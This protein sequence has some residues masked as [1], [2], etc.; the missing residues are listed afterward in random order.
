M[1]KKQSWYREKH[2][3]FGGSV[4]KIWTVLLISS[5]LSLHANSYPQKARITLDVHDMSLENILKEIESKTEFK[6]I[7]NVGKIDTGR[8]VSIKADNRPV[9]YILDQI[10]EGTGIGYVLRDKL[11]LLRPEETG[12]AENRDR[13]SEVQGQV[14]GTVTDE[15]GIPLPGVTVLIQGST[16]GTTT[17][18]DGNYSIN[19]SAEATLQFSYIGFETLEEEVANRT[20]VDIRMETSVEEIEEVVIIGYGEVKKENITGSVGVVDME[21]FHNQAPAINVDQGLQGLVAGVNVSSPNGQPGSASKIRIRGTTSL[22]GSNQPLFVIDGIPVVAESN[23]PIGGSEG[24]SL[25]QELDNQGLSTP[26]GNINPNDIESI[27]VLKDASAAAIYGSRAAN[28]VIII[29]T[30]QGSRNSDVNFEFDLSSSIQE[31]PG[32]DV[33]NATQ[34]K[35]AWTTAVENSSRTDAF[36]NAVRDGSYFGDAD[37]NWEDIM[38][39]GNRITT[40]A[41]FSARGGTS[42]TRYSASLS[43]LDE[44]AGFKGSERKRYTI[45]L[46]LN[47]NA[48]RTWNFGTR[49][50][51]TYA[52]QFATDAGLYDRIFRFRPDLPVR[53]EDGNYTFSPY[54][55]LE[56]PAALSEANN[57]NNTFLFLGTFFTGLELMEG[58]KAETRLSVN[59]NSGIQK[60]FYPAFTFR[61]GWS[62]LQGTGEG[63]A[64]DSRSQSAVTQW[65]TT[66]TYFRQWDELHHV[67]AVLGTTFENVNKSY[68]KAFGEGFSN[69]I[70]DNVSSATLGNGGLSTSE[71]SGLASYFGRLYYDYDSRYLAT[72]VGRVDGSSKFAKENKYAFFPAVAVAWRASEEEFLRGNKTLNNLKFKASIGKTGQQDLGAYQWRTLYETYQYG[73]ESAVILTQLGNDRL[74]WETTDQLDFG[75]EFGLFDNRISGEFGYYRKDTYDAIFPVIPPVSTGIVTVLANAGETRNTGLELLLHADLIRSKDFSWNIRVN[76]TRNKNVLVS[77]GD[78]YKDENGIV[79]GIPN[80][81]GQLKEGSAIGLIYGYEAE[82]IFQDQ[83][84]I[85]ALNAAA[86]DGVYQHAETAPGDLRFKDITGPDGVPDGKITVLDQTIIGDAQPDVFGGFASTF[87]YKQLSLSAQFSYSIGNDLFWYAQA[88]DV[89]FFNTFSGEN[90]LVDAL[91][92]WTPENPTRQPRA[93]YGDPNNNRRISSHYVH[94]ASYLRLNTLNLRYDMPKRILQKLDFIDGIAVYGVAQNLFTITGYPGANPQGGTLFNNDIS[95]AGRDTNR[96]PIPSIYSLGINI[97]F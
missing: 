89:N 25:G 83:A 85:D 69:G 86:P 91:N 38:D 22:F 88:Q 18:I 41:N 63:Y 40:T 6:F 2:A 29:N 17:D 48:T 24:Q 1:K 66:L 4:R 50:Q 37:T 54:Y 44:K 10:L 97:K 57:A 34:F 72:L 23:I 51:A 74:K 12:N 81:G 43:A 84:A 75:L 7:Y 77:V 45:N 90:K 15:Q 35:E 93:I 87:R 80:N 47:T 14:R 36:A 27:S 55:N 49:I 79:S 9:S 52:E 65:Q 5:F 13:N 32:L 8:K 60:S 68:N 21:S 46:N 95:G 92:G 96:Y 42:A 76:A 20:V 82:G 62:R 28:G 26:V 71:G 53:D 73:G 64:Q 94:D 19:V 16:R 58:L 78:D 67:D 31:L 39:P 11:I 33:F 3:L 59:Y 70:L 61:G 30:K 56:S